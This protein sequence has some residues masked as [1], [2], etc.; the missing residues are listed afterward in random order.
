M[1]AAPSC[2]ARPWS[3]SG[4]SNSNTSGSRQVQSQACVFQ[5]QCCVQ[6]SCVRA[7]HVTE[8][9]HGCAQPTIGEVLCGAALLSAVITIVL[10][11]VVFVTVGVWLIVR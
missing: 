2:P 7:G 1:L 4:S 10:G 8:L 9:L 11:F 3:L 6:L 5:G